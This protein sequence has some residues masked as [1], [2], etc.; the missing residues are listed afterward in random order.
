QKH[1]EWR[2]SQGAGAPQTETAAPATEVSPEEARQK[3]EDASE[4]ISEL[5]PRAVTGVASADPKDYP[6]DSHPLDH[7]KVADA[8]EAQ[9]KGSDSAKEVAE[10]HRKIAQ[11]RSER[12]S[13][14]DHEQLVQDLHEA[15]MSEHAVE[16]EQVAGKKRAVEKER[17]ETVRAVEAMGEDVE[18][19][20]KAREEEEARPAREAA[21]ALGEE[22]DA[23]KQAEEKLQEADDPHAEA[24][25][26]W[27]DKTAEAEA[28]YEEDLQA[29]EAKKKEIDAQHEK[30]LGAHEQSVD[31]A[32]AAAVEEH[33]HKLDEQHAAAT[34]EW[35]EK[36]KA[37]EDHK[38]KEE[39]HKART[40][41]PPEPVGPKPVFKDYKDAKKFD[42][43][44]AA[45]EKKSNQYKQA[46]AVH[47]TKKHAH[48]AEARALA[49]KRPKKP[50]TKPKKP[51]ATKGAPKHPGYTKGAPKKPKHPAPPKKPK[52]PEKPKAEDFAA[53]KPGTATEKASHQDHVQR[54]NAARENIQSHLEQNKELSPEDRS[55]LEQIH[56][57][58]GG[59]TE[60]DRMPTKEQTS[61]L[62]Q[63]ERLG[64][65]HGKKAHGADEAKKVEQEMEEVR[66]PQSDMEHAQLADHKAKAESMK[67]NI[68]SH[69]DS[70]DADPNMSPEEKESVTQKLKGLLSSLDNHAKLDTLP[71]KDQSAE[72]K[73]ISKL[74]GEHGKKAY[75]PPKAG[76]EAATKT[77]TTTTTTGGGRL[78]LRGAFESGRRV[79]AAAAR[80]AQDPY[81]AGDLGPQALNLASRG[82]LSAGGHLL[83]SPKRQKRVKETM[84]GLYLDLEGCEGLVIQKAVNSPNAGTTTD[85]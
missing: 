63:L 78:N 52:H 21:I 68:Q 25:Q 8:I 81:G 65:A 17:D 70:I 30:D 58:L 19:R 42:K 67:N 76:E 22:L 82:V 44:K 1:A 72:M 5:D 11:Q 37:Y 7:Y 60:L 85:G 41:E 13:A 20:A 26:A 36:N 80:A 38:K 53:K 55:K 59:H 61:E 74:A 84:K 4:A 54:A 18:A 79:G 69:L 16:H 14:D 47:K 56:E 83:N 6:E 71:T 49:T 33:K 12:L 48:S 73:E 50:G 39:E 45:W 24:M 15:G 43:D 40:P 75:E 28:K 62:K 9:G 51:A 10:G 23:K 3:T 32:H 29:H 57:G 35:E 66:P 34:K 46:V 77:K 27:E 2:A 31:D 64:G